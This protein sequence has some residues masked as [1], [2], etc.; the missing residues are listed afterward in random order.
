MC[1]QPFNKQ[2]LPRNAAS[3]APTNEQPS[4]QA[5]LVRPRQAATNMPDGFLSQALSAPADRD[6]YWSFVE[7]RQSRRDNLM[8]QPWAADESNDGIAFARLPAFDPLDAPFI[9]YRDMSII[10]NVNGNV[11]KC[12]SSDY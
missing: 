6:A 3:Q 4:D 10:F 11:R 2:A 9:S 8:R 7:R 1:C 12:S 5:V